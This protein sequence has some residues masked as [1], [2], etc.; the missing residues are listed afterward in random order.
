MSHH[1]DLL[2][3]G[4]GCAGLALGRELARRD[5]GL[6]ALIVEPRTQYTEDRTWCF[7]QRSDTPHCGPVAARWA[8][9][10]ISDSS[11]ARQHAG[12]EWHY[13]MVRAGTYYDAACGEI[14]AAP[15]ISLQSGTRAGQ[16]QSDDRGTHVETDAGTIH[17]Q[18]VV[19]TRPP[20]AARLAGAPIAQVFSGA[21]VETREDRFDPTTALVMDRLRGDA[22]QVAFDYV[23]PLT[24]RRA[25]IEHTVF[26][27]RPLAPKT[28]DHACN[29]E[30]TRRAGPAA[31][32]IRRE[33]GWLP[34]GLPERSRNDGPVIF[35]G[36]GAGALRASSGYGFRRIQAWADECADE[37]AAGRAPIPQPADPLFRRMMDHIFLD[38][39][40]RQPWA[41]PGLFMALA[42]TLS[43]DG[44]ARFMS[45]KATPQDWTR[46]VLA[47]PKR[48]FL[49]A[50]LR[51][52]FHRRSG[53]ELARC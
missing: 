12:E 26:S 13:A 17:A 44:F 9:W 1:V 51:Q 45:D 6:S 14:S 52:M 21:E 27:A 25:L 40:A 4:G 15:S 43:G 30:V 23:L 10:Q 11:A 16:I 34:M 18:W 49:T 53:P 2:I 46:T 33:R 29:A 24:P 47:L 31:R 20:D 38:A 32:I 39:L 48:P 36:T 7:W 42:D 41:G 28:L 37:L 50:A 8:R 5:A 35:A 3:L 19:D 22:N